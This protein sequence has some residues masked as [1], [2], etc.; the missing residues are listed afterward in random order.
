M[1]RKCHRTSRRIHFSMEMGNVNHE[2]GTGFL[3][4]R[5]YQQLRGWSLLVVGCHT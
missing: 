1:G 3:Y 5:S 2:L 4:I